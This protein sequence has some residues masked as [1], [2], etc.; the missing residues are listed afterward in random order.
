ME[1]H[2]YDIIVKRKQDSRS[3]TNLEETFHVTP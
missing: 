3:L 2:T 1:L